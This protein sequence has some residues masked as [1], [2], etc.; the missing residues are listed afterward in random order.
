[1][2]GFVHAC[3]R[4]VC[5][6]FVAGMFCGTSRPAVALQTSAA[7]TST[8][9]NQSQIQAQI[10]ADEK[11]ARADERLAKKDEKQAHIEEAQARVEDR[12]VEEFAAEDNGVNVYRHSTMVHAFA[13]VFGLSVETTAR[14]FEGLN[15]LILAVAVLWFVVRALPRAL[16]SRAERIQKNLQEARLATDDANRRLQDVEQRLAR[17]DTEI[18]SLKSQ[19]EQETVVDEARIR[20]SMEEAQQRLVHA[21]EQE[22][23]SV[24]ANAQRRLKTLAADLILEY[25]TH[26]VSLDTDADRSLVRNFV[27]ELGDK[28]RSAGRN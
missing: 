16:R 17:L 1:M 7:S 19:A 20:A 14:I 25:A 23:A 2:R 11:K 18:S 3:A 8:I 12:A 21:A 5:M 28:G 13:R 10:Q 27:S 4:L 9:A 24:G 22:I 26:H 15:F 6:I